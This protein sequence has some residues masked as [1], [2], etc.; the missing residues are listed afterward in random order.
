MK[1]NYRVEWKETQRSSYT[2]HY[3]TDSKYDA[4]NWYASKTYHSAYVRIIDCFGDTVCE[5][6]K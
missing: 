1:T 4:M 3:D 6:N 2:H 5:F